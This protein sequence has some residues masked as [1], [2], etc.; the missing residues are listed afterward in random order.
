VIPRCRSSLAS[1]CLGLFDSDAA[2]SID[3]PGT[4][5]NVNV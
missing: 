2:F 4:I 1:I 3:D 5:R